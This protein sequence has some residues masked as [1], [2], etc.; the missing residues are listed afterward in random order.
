M[1]D[2]IWWNMEQRTNEVMDMPRTEKMNGLC[3][4]VGLVLV[5]HVNVVVKWKQSCNVLLRNITTSWVIVLDELDEL[6]G[7]L[8]CL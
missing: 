7:L 2:E 5:E 8:N 6:D 4:V 1:L 3:D